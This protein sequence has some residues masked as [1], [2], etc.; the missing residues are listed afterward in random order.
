M[1]ILPRYIRLFDVQKYR[2]I[3][4]IVEGI[5]RRDASAKDVISLLK[6]AKEVT[7]GNDFI[8]YN[9]PDQEE[10][11]PEEMQERIDLIQDFGIVTWYNALDRG[12]S[13]GYDAI[14][15]LYSYLCCPKYQQSAY[16]DLAIS[17]MTVE[18]EM[19]YRGYYIC[20]LYLPNLISY[21]F[22]T[23]ERLP[24]D[25]TSDPDRF[26]IFS[27]EQFPEVIRA[28]EI[29]ILNLSQSDC[30]SKD[31]MIETRDEC[32]TIY[33]RLNYLFDVVNLNPNYTFFMEEHTS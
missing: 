12:D 23:V 22:S 14:R 17:D 2:E 3:Q 18:Y 16:L 15:Q 6:A 29:D 26:S 25:P 19:I 8:M 32:L 5:A 27:R 10:G 7:E 13:G 31:H 1:G 11:Y 30:D 21:E 4:P 33:K 20:D 9:D 24:R 28:T